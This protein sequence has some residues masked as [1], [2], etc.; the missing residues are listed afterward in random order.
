MTLLVPS[1]PERRTRIEPI[2]S[3]QRLALRA[4]D[5]ATYQTISKALTGQHVR[6]T[7][8]CGRLEFLTISSKHGIL[9]RFFSRLIAILTEELNLPIL[10]CGDMTCDNEAAMCGIE[11]D[12]CFY[13]ENEPRVRGQDEIDLTVDPPPDLAVEI[14]ISPAP[15]NR[16]GIYTALQIREVW[17]LDGVR[18]SVHQLTDSGEYTESTQSRYFRKIEVA[19]LLEFIERRTQTDEN[20]LRKSFREW[21]RQQLAA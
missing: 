2:G 14:E 5:W 4:I 1:P 20:S 11:P 8:D 17:R 19:G 7:Y 9:S 18:L 10:S 6:L 13:L 16:M 15:R 12:E 21:V 3:E